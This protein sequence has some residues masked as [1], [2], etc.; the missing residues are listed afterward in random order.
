M[1]RYIT[2]LVLLNKTINITTSASFWDNFL[3]QPIVGRNRV[4]S[5]SSMTGSGADDLQVLDYQS[6]GATYG[7]IQ[8]VLGSNR[9]AKKFSQ[10][11]GWNKNDVWLDDGD[12]LVL[13]GGVLTGRRN[14][15]HNSNIPARLGSK[16]KKKFLPGSRVIFKKKAERRSDRGFETRF[17]PVQAEPSLDQYRFWLRLLGLNL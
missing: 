15:K 4:S 13:R 5:D 12:L 10:S 1:N 14:I 3:P 17:H 7:L 2:I 11:S 9:R 16:V 8:N 6:P